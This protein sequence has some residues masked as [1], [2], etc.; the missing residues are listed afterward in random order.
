MKNLKIYS[1]VFFTISLLFQSLTSYSQVVFEVGIEK[2]DMSKGNQMSYMID[3]P[4]ADLETVQ[5]NWIKLLQEETKEKAV[6]TDHE[7]FIKG[8]MAKEV[9]QKPINIYSFVYKVDSS[10]RIYSFYE[11]DSVFF[12]YSGEETDIAG[13]KMYNG[14]TNF[15]RKFAVEQYIIAV[16]GEMEEEQNILK[17]LQS[18]LKKLEKENESLHKEIKENEQNIAEA[19]DE[20]GLL[21]ADNERLL[22]SLTSQRASV[23]SI[24]DSELK[25]EANKELKSLESE[26]K[27]VGNRIEKEQKD[28]VEFESDIKSC[29][30]EIDKNLDLQEEKKMEIILQ[31]ELI[32]SV[33][34]KL[35]GIK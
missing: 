24:S 23:A 8:T 9:V 21:D 35:E 5:K 22:V 26:K 10:I 3:I 25:K 29:K 20:L 18:D 32:K 28:I 31:E 27:K 13:E 30:K 16:K 1:C 19:N 4:Q 2:R 34:A 15:K 17:T 6:I 7:I 14:I 12:E 33:T 11:I